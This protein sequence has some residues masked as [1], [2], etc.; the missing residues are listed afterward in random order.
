[1]QSGWRSASTSRK[2]TPVHDG[3]LVGGIVIASG[4]CGVRAELA[5]VSPASSLRVLFDIW[6]DFTRLVLHSRLIEP[7]INAALAVKLHDQSDHVF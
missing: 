3:G 4:R 5:H 1:M 6:P 7:E 2:A